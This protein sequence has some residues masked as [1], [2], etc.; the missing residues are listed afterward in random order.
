VKRWW[1]G[2]HRI[3]LARESMIGLGFDVDACPC[4]DDDGKRVR[5]WRARLW[6]ACWILSVSFNEAPANSA[7]TSTH[8]EGSH[9]KPE[10]H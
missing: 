1:I 9:E 4:V 10:H 6:F 2:R 8:P 5:L 3:I 7:I